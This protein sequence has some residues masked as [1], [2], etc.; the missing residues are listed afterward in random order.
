M[1]ARLVFTTWQTFCQ[2]RSSRS[3]ET[4]RSIAMADDA[5]ATRGVP[6][7][8]MVFE[9]PPI[10]CTRRGATDVRSNTPAAAS[11]VAAAAAYVVFAALQSTTLAYFAAFAA[12]LAP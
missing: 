11:V 8:I 2:A 7:P 10:N 3:K 4:I 1:Q 6:S 9:V 5:P 12:S